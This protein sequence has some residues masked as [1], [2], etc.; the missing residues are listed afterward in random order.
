VGTPP[1]SKRNTLKLD[2]A[3]KEFNAD[4]NLKVFAPFTPDNLAIV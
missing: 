4:L 2:I 3:D 1:Q